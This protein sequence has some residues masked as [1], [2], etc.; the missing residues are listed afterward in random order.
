M[1][2]VSHGKKSK[3]SRKHE[4]LTHSDVKR[5]VVLSTVAGIC[6]KDLAVRSKESKSTRVCLGGEDGTPKRDS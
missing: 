4:V 1:L 6:V 2:R 5:N 3:V